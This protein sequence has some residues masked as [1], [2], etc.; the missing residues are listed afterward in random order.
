MQHLYTRPE[1]GPS[2]ERLRPYSPGGILNAL[3]S[4]QEGSTPPTP[5]IHRLLLGLTGYLIRV[6]PLAF[7]PQR[8]VRPRGP[9]SPRVFLLISTHF[10]AT[11]AIPPPSTDLKSHS[12]QRTLPVEQGDFTPY[13]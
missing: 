4:A 9:P 2:F 1:G 6:A 7:A 3:A 5:S 12:L 13:L 11:P 10:T 8:Q